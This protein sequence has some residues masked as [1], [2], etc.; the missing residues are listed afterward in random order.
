MK[1]L[2]STFNKETYTALPIDRYIE[3]SKQSFDFLEQHKRTGECEQ[4]YFTP[5]LHGS[6]AIWEMS[7]SDEIVRLMFENPMRPYS[8]TT[9]QPLIES[10]VV[11]RA[12]MEW[13]EKLGKKQPARV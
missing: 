6:I 12:Q 1:F 2:V 11:A 13:L 4:V 7:S 8:D 3:L 9:V 5:D 10:A